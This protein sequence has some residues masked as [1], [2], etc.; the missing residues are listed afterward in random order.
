MTS[1]IITYFTCKRILRVGVRRL[2]RRDAKRLCRFCMVVAQLK[3]R[4]IQL[5]SMTF[6]TVEPQV[7]TNSRWFS[8]TYSQGD[9][10]QCGLLI[11]LPELT[12]I[13]AGELFKHIC[14]MARAVIAHHKGHILDQHVP[15]GEENPFGLTHTHIGKVG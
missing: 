7:N 4:R 3:G 11:V 9:H 8:I 10:V 6:L 15:P 12:G 2:R 14:E 13:E 1:N 5:N